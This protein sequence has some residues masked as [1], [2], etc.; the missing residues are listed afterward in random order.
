[1]VGRMA[2]STS[3]QVL[4]GASGI[5]GIRKA[6]CGLP[7]S[8]KSLAADTSKQRST[9]AS[10]IEE[11]L[12]REYGSLAAELDTLN[13]QQALFSAKERRL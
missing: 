4:G 7:L 5:G 3:Q 1:M 13:A 11:S 9:A 12:D 10:A 2:S 6:S 8:K